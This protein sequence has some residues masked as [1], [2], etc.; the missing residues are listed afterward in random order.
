M[1]RANGTILHPALVVALFAATIGL[2]AAAQPASAP[3]SPALTIPEAVSARLF[4]ERPIVAPGEPLIA[5][6]SLKNSGNAP[7]VVRLSMPQDDAASVSLPLAAIF[8][9]PTGPALTVAPRGELPQ[10]VLPPPSKQAEL[11]DVTIAA[12]GLIGAELDLREYCT[13]LRYPG[14]YTVAWRPL[15]PGGPVASVEIRVEG[16]K[17]AICVTDYGK[18]SIELRYDEAPKNVENFVDLVREGF[19]NGLSLHRVV[20]GF[21]VSAGCPNGDGTGTRPDGKYVPAELTPEQFNLGTIAMAHLPDDPNSASCQ[22]FICLDRLP[23]LD[24]THTIIGICRDEASLA[25][26]RAISEVGLDRQYR[27]LRPIA[28]RSI[29]LIDRDPKARAAALQQGTPQMPASRR[30]P[31][32]L[33]Q[34]R[35]EREA[36]PTD[37]GQTDMT[38]ANADARPPRADADEVQAMRERIRARLPRTAQQSPPARYAP[39]PAAPPAAPRVGQMQPMTSSARPAPAPPSAASTTNTPPPPMKTAAPAPKTSAPMQPAARPPAAPTN[40]APAKPPTTSA[41]ARPSPTN[42][43]PMTPVQPSAP[44]PSAPIPSAPKPSAPKPGPKG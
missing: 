11:R 24:R 13:A 3:A 38:P 39:P 23:A 44:K 25:T 10:V 31:L 1:K 14:H 22:F 16:R 37:S 5:Q 17:D 7:A 20:P 28:I 35:A 12:R 8:G 21:V 15:G 42:M 19:Y 27:P 18:L 33:P 36:A 2:R 34:T 9:S 32:R 43:A 40:R 30:R 4:M 29:N 26:L 41:P 6:F